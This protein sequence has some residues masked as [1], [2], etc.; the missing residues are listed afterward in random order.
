MVY[1]YGQMGWNTKATGRRIERST[2]VVL[3]CQ[4]ETI[5]RVRYCSIKPTGKALISTSLELHMLESGRMTKFMVME[6]NPGQI[7]LTIKVA[8]R[9]D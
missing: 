2:R 5:T 7:V 8:M 9:E 1:K 6:L 3:S 4:M